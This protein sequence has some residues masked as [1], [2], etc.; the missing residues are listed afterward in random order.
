[1]LITISANHQYATRQALS[2]PLKEELEWACCQAVPSRMA[3]G[4]HAA[5]P[6]T[7]YP[8]NRTR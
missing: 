2:R 8:S 3:S 7:V 1:M 5:M 4:G 6:Y